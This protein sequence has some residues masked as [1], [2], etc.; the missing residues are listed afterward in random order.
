MKRGWSLL[1]VFAPIL[2]GANLEHCLADTPKPADG[3]PITLRFCEWNIGHFDHGYGCLPQAKHS[4]LDLWK[5]VVD[6][7]DVDI[8]GFAE[9]HPTLF[10]GSSFPDVLGS[11]FGTVVEGSTRKYNCNAVW[12][13]ASVGRLLRT[14]EVDFK[15]QVQS[16]YYLDT[17]F[18]IAGRKVHVVATHLDWELTGNPKRRELQ[19][20]ELVEAFRGEEYVILCGDFNTN[21]GPQEWK[22]FEAAGW[23]LAVPSDPAR[24]IMTGRENHGRGDVSIDNIIVKGFDVSGLGTADDDYVLS[25]HRPIFCTLT[26][27]SAEG[28]PASAP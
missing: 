22:I 24:A 10:D 20:R 15:D 9:Y 26:M 21:E 3:K 28:R 14:R 17:V 13:K 23:S 16:R 25:D 7:L 1:V 19:M 4:R 18:E 8:I 2:A 12:A 6:S 11:R 5:P 27:K